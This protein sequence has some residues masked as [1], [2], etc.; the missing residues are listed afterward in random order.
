LG[1]IDGEGDLAQV[2]GMA[3]TGNFA[4]FMRRIRGGD[5]AAAEELVRKYEPLIRREVRMNMEDSR[6]V[7]TLD[8]IDI[9]Q[10]VL[11]SFFARA[12][13]GAYDLDE[14]AQLVRL[15]IKIARNKLASKARWQFR[16]KRDAHRVDA[17]S[18]MLESLPGH[19][20]SPSQCVSGKELFERICSLLTDEER[21]ISE[22]RGQD[23]SWE[24]IAS[25]LG[26]TPDGRRMQLTRAIDRITLALD[27]D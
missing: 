21:Q 20:E 17:E 5:E 23:S 12:A 7:R 3:S 6:L 8:S 24:E 15:L 11:A 9:S 25:R 18:G 10:S 22:L 14:P 27:L 26:G 19:G 4:E 1:S 13:A 16:D 2:V